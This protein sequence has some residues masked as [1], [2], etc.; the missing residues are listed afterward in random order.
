VLLWNKQANNSVELVQLVVQGGEY[1]VYACGTS[2][3]EPTLHGLLV[4]QL[5]LRSLHMYGIKIE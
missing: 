2:L 5:D 4:S 3:L 1:E